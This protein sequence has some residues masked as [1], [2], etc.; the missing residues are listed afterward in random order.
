MG[1]ITVVYSLIFKFLDSKLEDRKE[2]PRILCSTEH[3]LYDH[4][5][6]STYINYNFGGQILNKYGGVSIFVQETPLF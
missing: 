5:I 4:E 6:Y 1:K 2:F 3:H